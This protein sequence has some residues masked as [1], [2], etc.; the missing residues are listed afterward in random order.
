[1]KITG[2][3]IAAFVGVPVGMVLLHH[4]HSWITYGISVV[5]GIAAGKF[6]SVRKRTND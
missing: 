6:D 1:V 4:G 3:L 2:L 5:L